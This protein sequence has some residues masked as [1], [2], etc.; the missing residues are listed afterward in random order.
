MVV[1]VTDDVVVAV[2]TSLLDVDGADFVSLSDTSSSTIEPF[3]PRPF[4][5]SIRTCQ[6]SNSTEMY[7]VLIVDQLNLTQV[8]RL[9]LEI[10]I[11]SQVVICTG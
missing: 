6:V 11:F 2:V 9:D 4:H 1:E 8:I 3:T 10:R 7:S 5:A